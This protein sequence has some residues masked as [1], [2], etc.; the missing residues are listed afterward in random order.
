M[1]RRQ[2]TERV[3]VRLPEQS[4]RA[5]WLRSIRLSGFTIATLTVLVLTVVVLAPSLRIFVQQQQQIAQLR[6]DVAAQK[7][8]VKNL[9]DERA[10]WDDPSYIEAQARERLNYVYP[11]EYSYLVIDDGQTVT[12]D[13]GQPISDKVQATQ[14]DWIRMLLS[15]VLTAGLTEDKPGQIVAP[16]IKDKNG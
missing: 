14:V 6:A 1:T 4:A 2:R 15:S 13:D 3:P 9:G 7:A 16:V 8:G 11:G 10:R 5:G 12:T